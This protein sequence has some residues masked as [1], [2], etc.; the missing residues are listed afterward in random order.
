MYIQLDWIQWL[1]IILGVSLAMFM[2]F[3]ALV[4]WQEREP[5]AMKRALVLATILLSGYGIGALMGTAVSGIFLSLSLLFG[6]Y[7][8]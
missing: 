4:S 2:V 5:K 8:I 3:F 6:I 1:T 7:A